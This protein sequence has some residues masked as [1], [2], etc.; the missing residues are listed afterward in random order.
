MNLEQIRDDIDALDGQL[1][2][3]L[4]RRMALVSQVAAYKRQTGKAVLDSK[5]EEELLAKVASLVSQPDFKDTVLATYSAILQESRAYQ[6][7]KL[8]EEQ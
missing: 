5:R 8:G 2:A 3:L 1:V 7:R 4:E 6:V